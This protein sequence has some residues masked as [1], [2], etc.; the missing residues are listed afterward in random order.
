MSM[1]AAPVALAMRIALGLSGIWR[2]MSRLTIMTDETTHFG[3][4]SVPLGEKQGVVDEV[5]HSVA[6]PLRPH[7]RPHVGRACT[8]LWKDALVTA[9]RPPRRAALPPSR[10]RRRHRR[11]GLPHPRCRRPADPRDGA[12]HQ[13]RHARR[14]AASGPASAMTGG[15]ISSRRMPR[16]CR[17]QMRSPSTPTRSPSA[18]ATCRA[19][20]RR[21]REAHRVLQARRALPVPRILEG[22]RAGPRRAL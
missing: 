2:P 4:K 11:R 14:S 16:R 1:I 22:R 21:L 15:S 8:G 18:S 6:A 5:F 7:E 9:L 20:T 10:R 19:S 12:R 3:F 13:R 17:S